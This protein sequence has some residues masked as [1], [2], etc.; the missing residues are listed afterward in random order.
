MQFNGNENC[1][2]SL[3]TFRLDLTKKSNITH[4][5]FK[6]QTMSAEKSLS[7]NVQ[8]SMQASQQSSSVSSTSSS[9]SMS[10]SVRSSSAS[11]RASAAMSVGAQVSQS[12]SQQSSSNNS[13]STSGMVNNIASINDSTAALLAANGMML[14]SNPSSIAG[15]FTHFYIIISSLHEV[16]IIIY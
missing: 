6:N 3:N 12:S 1:I 9:S 11:R 4:T 2:K 14:A 7:K 10:S 5:K 8:V 16:F 15:I 13:F